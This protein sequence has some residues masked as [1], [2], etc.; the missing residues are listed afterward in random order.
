MKDLPILVKIN[1][2]FMELKENPPEE[3]YQKIDNNCSSALAELQRNSTAG[4]FQPTIQKAFAD[5]A[6]VQFSQLAKNR[7]HRF[8]GNCET[9]LGY[10]K[11]EKSK[12]MNGSRKN[13]LT[14]WW[15]SKID[16]TARR[17]LSEKNYD[18]AAIP[19]DYISERPTNLEPIKKNLEIIS[20]ILCPKDGTTEARD[21]ADTLKEEIYVKINSFVA[22]VSIIVADMLSFEVDEFS[23][24]FAE[25]Q[26]E[27][28]K[29]SF[30]DD[31]KIYKCLHDMIKDVD[32]LLE[33]Q[34]MENPQ[35]NSSSGGGLVLSNVV[36]VSGLILSTFYRRENVL[37]TILELYDYQPKQ[38]VAQPASTMEEK[39][40]SE[41]ENEQQQSN[42]TVNE[43]DNSNNDVISSEI[44]DNSQNESSDNLK[45][46]ESDDQKNDKSDPDASDDL[47]RPD[48][49]Q[50]TKK[51]SSNSKLSRKS[52]L[53]KSTSSMNL[54]P[55]RRNT[56][57]LNE[58]EDSEYLSTP[59]V[60]STAASG[61]LEVPDPTNATRN[62]RRSNN[63]SNRRMTSTLGNARIASKEKL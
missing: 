9:V 48:F 28:K 30:S 51:E 59:F 29:S 33:M 62:W 12:F 7:L 25:E 27:A 3:F 61:D 23:V 4:I 6:S 32:Y 15:L 18:D 5:L 35:K 50:I 36:P 14:E 58:D 55:S 10:L 22:D 56:Q 40:K 54:S 43:D 11:I 47:V 39:P 21:L 41:T 1:E 2:K 63:N 44:N 26:L 38:P 49:Q 16:K 8:M 60:R 19:E 45:K 46:D 17:F 34:E 53:R 24:S 37:R 13:A 52:P 42:N 20:N 57:N 31:D